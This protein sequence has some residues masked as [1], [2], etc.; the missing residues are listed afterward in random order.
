MLK[1]VRISSIFSFRKKNMF[2][3]VSTTVQSCTDKGSFDSKC[4]NWLNQNDSVTLKIQELSRIQRQKRGWVLETRNFNTVKNVHHFSLLLC[5][6]VILFLIIFFS[7]FLYLVVLASVCFFEA[8]CEKN[9][10]FSSLIFTLKKRFPRY[11]VLYFLILVP[12]LS[13]KN[14]D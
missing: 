14:G 12:M 1:N 8:F 5:M 4:K 7:P 6:S 9:A 10:V 11:I 13:H 3:L 2:I